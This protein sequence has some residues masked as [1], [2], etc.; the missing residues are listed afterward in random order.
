M[1][2]LSI[3][4]HTF[5]DTFF[6]ILCGIVMGIHSQFGTTYVGHS[7]YKNIF[8]T[9]AIDL[10]HSELEII[11]NNGFCYCKKILRVEFPKL[12]HLDYL[13]SIGKNYFDKKVFF[14]VVRD[15]VK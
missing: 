14:L 12:L 9:T 7:L 2:K 3:L 6:F 1:G 13:K 4:G 15:L 5:V 11:L 8:V 10:E